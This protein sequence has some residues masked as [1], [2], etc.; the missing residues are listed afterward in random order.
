MC[1][2]V[3]VCVYLCVFVCTCPCCDGRLSQSSLTVHLT[4]P[5]L[6]L[7]YPTLPDHIILPDPTTSP[8]PTR[9]LPWPT[10]GTIPPLC[11]LLQVTDIKVVTV[12]LEGLENIL[13]AGKATSDLG[14]LT[15]CYV[16]MYMNT[17]SCMRM[18]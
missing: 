5:Y 9:P 12:A 6:T 13:K 2:C 7:P 8:Y 16:H 3:C 1:V 15:Q 18:H 11:G 17:P 4:L 10:L 14:N